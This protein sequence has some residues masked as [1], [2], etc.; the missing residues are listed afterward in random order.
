MKR[1][2]FA[3]VVL[4]SVGCNALTGA[5]D[6]SFDD[7]ESGGDDAS[8]PEASLPSDA[9][10]PRDSGG[11]AATADAS[12]DAPADAPPPDAEAGPTQKRVF[13]TSTTM[14]GNLGGLAGADAKCQTAANAAGLG[15]TFIAYVSVENVIDA[16]DR[17]TGTGPWHLVTG[18]LAVTK[19]QVTNAPISHAI[20]RDESGALVTGGQVWTA[21]GSAGRFLDDDCAGWTVGS[22]ARHAAVG[23]P[24][25][26][27]NLWVAANP[28]DCNIANRLYCFEQ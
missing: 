23:N 2:L 3:A 16:R 17:L 15:G 10:G 14:N 7:V 22:V 20:D 1:G 11:D 9:G 27:S 8:S 28:D 6:L 4:V 25:A 26:T 19:A 21:T 24:Q 18:P 12:V 13:V 5:G